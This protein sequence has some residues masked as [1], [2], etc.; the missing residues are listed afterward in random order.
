MRFKLDENLPLEIVA[1]LRTAGHEIDSVYEQ[2]LAGAP[3]EAILAAAHRERRIL[4][5][6]DKGI[7]DLRRLASSSFSGIV[8]FRPR[9]T[10]R[11]TTLEFVRRHLPAVLH[12]DLEGRLVI[13]SEG[14]LRIR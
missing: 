2:R 7:G 12:S 1:D 6:M 13:V 11:R 5:T 8:L 3:D 14:G 10:G 4:L 9:A